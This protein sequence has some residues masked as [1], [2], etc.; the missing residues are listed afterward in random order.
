MAVLISKQALRR[1]PVYLK[2]LKN[3]RSLGQEHVTAT[4]IAQEMGL[5][6]IQVRKDISSVSSR[7][8]KPMVGFRITD[9]IRDI[10]AF[11]AFENVKDAVIVGAGALGTALLGY[12]GFSEYG[13]NVVAAFDKDPQRIGMEVHGKP[14][15]PIENMGPIVRRLGVMIGIITVPA[16]AAQEAMDALVESG[17]R[18]IWNFAP[19]HLSEAEGILVQNESMASSLAVLSVRLKEQE[20]AR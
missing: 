15:Y 9:L 2:H 7:P 17:I 1:M 13:M 6:E 5:N 16:D 4:A 20:G 14:V 10:G 19:V 11:L 12:P 3:L 8:G 18:A